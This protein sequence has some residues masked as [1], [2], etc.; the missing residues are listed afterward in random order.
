[1]K[2]TQMGVNSLSIPT[3]RCSLDVPQLDCS[4]AHSMVFCGRF[5][6]NQCVPS[7]LEPGVCCPL[8]SPHPPEESAAR[9]GWLRKHH[10]MSQPLNLGVFRHRIV[11]TST[12]ELNLQGIERL[13]EDF[14]EVAAWTES[15]EQLAVIALSAATCAASSANV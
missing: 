5:I 3:T 12:L 11:A 10:V 6:C 4:V 15:K 14:R 9:I 8:N 2:N 7:S 13:K 1:M